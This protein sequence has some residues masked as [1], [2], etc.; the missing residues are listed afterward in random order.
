MKRHAKA[1]KYAVDI[2][3]DWAK[4]VEVEA[5]SREDAIRKVERM[6]A[7]RDARVDKSVFEPTE[8]F[9]IHCS[10]EENGKGEIVYF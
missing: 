4:C 9:D 2:H 10:G 7:D 3:W 1:R 5:V 8:D 6:V